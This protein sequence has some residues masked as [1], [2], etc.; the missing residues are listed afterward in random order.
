[1]SAILHY[2]TLNPCLSS[3]AN[4][5]CRAGK[6]TATPHPVKL[7]YQRCPD[8]ATAAKAAAE[9]AASAEASANASPGDSSGYGHS[10]ADSAEQADDLVAHVTVAAAASVS[11][12][13]LFL[14]ES[15]YTG[16]N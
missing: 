4:I 1:M 8:Q 11:Q 7:L 14:P 13:Q 12:V 6:V 2:L 15:S 5:A 16:R 9:Q 10:G 3:P